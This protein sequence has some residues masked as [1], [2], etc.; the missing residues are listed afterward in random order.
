MEAKKF[1]TVCQRKHAVEITL[2]YLENQRHEIEDNSR[3]V[4]R[5]AYQSRVALFDEIAGWYR[6]ELAQINCT[7]AGSEP[8][9]SDE[10]R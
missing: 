2:G 7:T 8:L 4:N 6:E 1:V 5:A 9:S 10:N 3:W